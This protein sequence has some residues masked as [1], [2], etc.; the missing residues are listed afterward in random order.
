LTNILKVMPEKSIKF[1]SFESSKTLLSTFSDGEELGA[2]K[3]FMAGSMSGVITHTV[4]FPMEVIRTRLSV[5]PKE[6]YSGIIDCA[7]KIAV[8]EGPFRPFFRGLSASLASTIP[9]SGVNL[10]TYELMKK[11]LYSATDKEPTIASL[12]VVGSASNTASQMFFYPLTVAKSRI[13]M[14]GM[15]HSQKKGLIPVLKDIV[16]KDGPKGL[17]RGYVDISSNDLTLT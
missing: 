13:I 9:Y 5:A 1:L 17:F 15:D 16:T 3:L 10:M 14:Q 6:M 11:A 7:R 8:S 2:T 4:T 12:M